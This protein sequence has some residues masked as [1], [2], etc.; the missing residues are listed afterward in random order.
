MGND[1]EKP[2]Q[3]K[4]QLGEHAIALA[5]QGQ[6]REAIEVNKN[7]IEDFPQEVNAYNRLGRAYIERG[8]YALARDAYNRALEIDPLNAIARKNLQRLSYLKE[9]AKVE[10]EP[11]KV[12]PQQFIEEMGKAEVV[13][14]FALAPKE[15][16]AKTTAGDKLSLKID[17]NSLQVENNLGEYLGQVE[18]R[19]A[20]RLIRLTAGGNRYSAAAVS[21][22]EE[23]MTIIIREVYQDP[24]QAGRLSFPPKGMEAVHTYA[25][26]RVMKV[27]TEYQGEAEGES[28]YTIIGGE[29]IEVLPEENTRSDEDAVSEED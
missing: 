2:L 4:K 11:D 8:D 16:R 28:G 29:E 24:G 27:E 26:D 14:L 6:W 21:S 18:P 25:G 22:T 15:V 7:I 9:S 3:L 12:E 20:L 10:S 5:L 1:E 13:S 17:G 19:R 23:A